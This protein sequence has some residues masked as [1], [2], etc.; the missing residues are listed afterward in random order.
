MRQ[1]QNMLYVSFYF[2]F[3]KTF[4]CIPVLQQAHDICWRLQVELIAISDLDAIHSF[5]H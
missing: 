2:H 3:L 5:I 1:K 4:I